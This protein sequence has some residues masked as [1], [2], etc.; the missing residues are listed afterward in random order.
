MAPMADWIPKSIPR[1]LAAFDDLRCL[2]FDYGGT[3]LE[4]TLKNLCRNN[5]NTSL[6]TDILFQ[7]SFIVSA[8][9]VSLNI[10]HTDL[11]PRNI[12]VSR[13]PVPSA[14]RVCLLG[15]S[16]EHSYIDYNSDVFVS[17]VDWVLAEPHVPYGGSSAGSSSRSERQ[18][19]KTSLN[20]SS[21]YR[22]P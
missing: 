10:A 7:A 21:L 5:S 14:R 8:L 13:L 15:P 2:A 12:V 20:S 6:V 22:S 1:I 17:I 11:H 16:G 19:R 9:A 18:V 4:T 3:T